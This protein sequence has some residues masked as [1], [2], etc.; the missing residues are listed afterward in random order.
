MAI[1]HI[2]GIDGYDDSEDAEV[3]SSELLAIVRQQRAEIDSLKS[4]LTASSAPPTRRARLS[5]GMPRL[6]RF[7]LTLTLALAVVCGGSAAL[8]SKNASRFD[9][10]CFRSASAA[11]SSSACP[12]GHLQSGR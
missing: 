10:G 3:S 7:A 5:I 11:V 4:R 1:T 8:A 2:Q 9:H 12:A 6:P